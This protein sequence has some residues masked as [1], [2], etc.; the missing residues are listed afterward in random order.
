MGERAG[1]WVAGGLAVVLVALL[2]A[3]GLVV[4]GDDDVDAGLTA[5]QQDVAGAA[6]REALAFL[7]VDH[8]DMDPLIDAVL[9]G[10]T[11][12]F[13]KQYASQRETLT[14]EAVRTEAT[15]TPEVVALGVGDQDAESATVLVAA[16]STVTNTG[17]GAD[18]QVRYYRLR[19]R[20]VREDD[21]W[22]TSDLQ[23]VR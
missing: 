13:A 17:T 9:D 19:L 15:S 11:G 4:T 5:A 16:N 2:V 8:R 18:G 1:R 6:R 12:G 14:S 22:L 23:F 20:L 3:I 7:T 21:R 10:A